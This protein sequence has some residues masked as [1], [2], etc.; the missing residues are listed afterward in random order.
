MSKKSKCCENFFFKL[1]IKK[2]ETLQEKV[3]ILWLKNWW[4]YEGG[5]KGIILWLKVVT[6]AEQKLHFVIKKVVS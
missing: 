4:S 1:T 2:H 6:L 5:V 3:V